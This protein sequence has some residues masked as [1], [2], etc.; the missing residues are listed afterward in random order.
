MSV[1]V[2]KTKAGTKIGYRVKEG[3]ALYTIY[4]EGGGQ[5]PASLEGM[6]TDARQTVN[7]IIT[8]LN[9]E[10]LCKPD[11]E[12]KRLKDN[13]RDSKKRPSKLKKVS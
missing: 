13:L 6:W 10:K 12:K 9:K 8:Y 3:D 4:F 5:L 2:G 1:I 11:A 7:A